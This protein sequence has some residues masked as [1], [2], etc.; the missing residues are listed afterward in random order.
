[1]IEDIKNICKNVLDI[2]GNVF[3]LMLFLAFPVGWWLNL[4]AMIKSNEPFG[5]IAA[6]VAGLFIFPLGAILGY[7]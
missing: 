2:T 7:F 5:M 3:G 1:M 4:V 6:R